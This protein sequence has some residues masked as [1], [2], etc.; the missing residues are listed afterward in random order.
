MYANNEDVLDSDLL[1][2]GHHGSKSSSTEEFL[3]GVSP[4]QA[5][6]SLGE[7]N[8]YKHPHPETLSKMNDLDISLFR[9]DESGDIKCVSDGENINC[10]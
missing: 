5:V 10:N 3:S 6:I 8:K 4:E 9:T 7:N 1:K 2:I